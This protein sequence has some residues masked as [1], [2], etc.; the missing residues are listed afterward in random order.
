MNKFSKN[1][2]QL[3]IH[4]DKISED[5]MIYKSPSTLYDPINYL[6]SKNLAELFLAHE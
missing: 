1:L 2:Q 5:L 6:F 3:I 4:L